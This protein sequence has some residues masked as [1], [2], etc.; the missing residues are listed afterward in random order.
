MRA[1]EVFQ[2][3]KDKRELLKLYREMPHNIR[4]EILSYAHGYVL[5]RNAED[6]VRELPFFAS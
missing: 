6:S 5:G 2:Y 4:I 1:D 3:E